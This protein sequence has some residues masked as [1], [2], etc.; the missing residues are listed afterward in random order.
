MSDGVFDTNRAGLALRLSTMRAS[1][2]P[3]TES[4]DE[5]HDRLIQEHRKRLKVRIQ[6]LWLLKTQQCVTREAV[7]EALD[8]HRHTVT[9]WLNKYEE[10]GIAE[11]LTIR[12][13]PNRKRVVSR[14]TLRSLERELTEHPEQFSSYKDVQAWLKQHYGIDVKYKTIYRLVRYEMGIAVGETTVPDESVQ[15]HSD[16]PA[17]T[18]RDRTERHA[19]AHDTAHSQP[20]EREPETG[21]VE[22]DEA[23]LAR[24]FRTAARYVSDADAS[25]GKVKA[26]V[27]ALA[28][29][30]R[31]Q[32]T[33][34]GDR[35][36][37]PP[38][39][40]SFSGPRDVEPSAE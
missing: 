13:R 33:P 18:E 23:R 17:L 10:G 12:T 22:S 6:A 16:A 15:A 4:V 21:Q 30:V 32:P 20:N 34:R 29:L 2:P 8:V 27:D 31:E 35:P 7:A 9:R 38:D 3:I 40:H 1:I 19:T 26:A 11:L 37:S 24:I 14:T 25:P 36:A 5:L 39:R 28:D